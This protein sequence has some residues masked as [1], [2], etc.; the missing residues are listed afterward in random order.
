MANG[1]AF[2]VGARPL[3]EIVDHLEGFR[4]TDVGSI[5]ALGMA[6]MI[7]GWFYVMGGRTGK[8]SF[9]L[10]TF[11]DRLLVPALLVPL[12]WLGELAGV[13]ALPFAILDPV[14]GIGAYL[15]WRREAA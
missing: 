13:V 8:A 11:V 12:W 4:M 7:I 1:A 5:R 9:V 6:L 14:L 3:I 15:L 10:A 2:I